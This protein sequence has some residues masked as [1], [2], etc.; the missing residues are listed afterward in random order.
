MSTEHIS[1]EENKNRIKRQALDEKKP[2]VKKHAAREKAP[3]SGETPASQAVSALQNMVGN[4]AVQRLL[5]QRA[6]DAPFQLDDETEGRIN[7]QRG[8]GQALDEGVRDRLESNLG[9][10]FSGVRVHTSPESDTLNQQLGAKAFTTG[11]DIFFRQDQYDPHSSSGQQLIAHEAAHVVQQSSGAVGGGP[12]MTVNAPGDIYEQQADSVASQVMSGA[13]EG[14]LQRDPMEEEEGVQMQE[15][16]DE[17]LQMQE[18]EDEELQMQE[19]E[20]EEL[21]METMPEEEE[22]IQAKKAL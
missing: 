16:E 2:A 4:R 10:D 21:Q 1:A 13:P 9:T 17:E 19:E 12:G 3:P 18:E 7:R 5:A 15:E 14:S 6:G 22:Q 20:D 11:S 8:G